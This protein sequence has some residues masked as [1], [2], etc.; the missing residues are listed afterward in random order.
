[1]Q[2]PRNLTLERVGVAESKAVDAGLAAAPTQPYGGYGVEVE[3]NTHLR[4][5]WRAVRK[6]LFL[7]LALT[8]LATG[9]TAVYM[10]RKVNIYEARVRV[11]VDMENSAPS[12][13]SKSSPIIFGSTSD[14]T[15]FNTQLQILSGSGLLRR[16]VKSLDLEHNR[17]YLRLQTT[18]RHST[19]E[20]LKQMVGLRGKG[21]PAQSPQTEATPLSISPATPTTRDDLAEANRLAPYVE[22]LQG[23]LNVSPVR[24]TRLPTK[25]TRLIDISY[26]HSDPQLAAKL[27]NTIADTFVLSNLETKVEA[28]NSTSDF[29]QKRIA[30]LQAQIRGGEER[31]SNYARGNDIVSLDAASNTVLERLVGLNQQLLGAENKRKEAEAAYRASLVSG[32]APGLA[33]EADRTSEIRDKIADLQSRRAQL[34]VDNTEEWIEVKELD[35][36]IAVLKTHLDDT[37]RQAAAT[38]TT[39]LETRYKQALAYEQSLRDAFLKQRGEMQTQNEAAIDYRI[40][41]QE[42][43]T[44]RSLLEGIL[45]RAKENDVIWSNTPNNI[46]VVDYAVMPRKPVGP[47]RL[48]VVGLSFAFSL[49]LSL[50]L[51]LFLEHINDA[52]VTPE[53]VERTLHLPSLAMIPAAGGGARLR[54]RPAINALHLRDGGDGANSDRALLLDA[55]TTSP[56]AEAYR[57]LRTTIL[58]ST[59]GRQPKT[60][61]VTSSLQAEGKTTS[62]VNTALVLSQTGANVL[63]IDADM[64]QPRVHTVFGM[65]NTDGLSTILASDASEAKIFSKIQRYKESNLYVLPAGVP[66]PNP[67]DLLGS[68]AMRRLISTLESNF[69]HIVIDSPPVAYFA[70]AVILSTVVDGVLLVVNSGKSSQGTVKRA[71]KVLYDVGAKIFGVI[72]NNVR[73]R[74][75]DYYYARY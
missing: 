21:G 53:D 19:W 25:E 62:S 54:L 35:E 18:S 15:Y 29:L 11:Q 28:S 55:E 13:S 43:Q 59:A 31:L 67:A 68:E 9:L 72:L 5:Y 70:D 32:A 74:T 7:V 41:Q 51:A 44:N 60:L 46:R 17:S 12:S 69:T 27:V 56:L 52:L 4:A 75:Q 58:L 39:N 49:G 36:Q 71:H 3:S 1:M 33:E 40:L 24:E 61:L 65:E 50:G 47:M 10:A 23:R 20:N 22:A 73:M 45:Q 16:V 42:V 48:M 2:E 64:R 26:T 34:L 6:H 37:R 8:V 66:P 57:H 30:E 14:P 38:V 63:L